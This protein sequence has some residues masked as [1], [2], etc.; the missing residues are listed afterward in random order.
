LLFWGNVRTA[1]YTELLQAARDAI[2]ESPSYL[3]P[4]R[5]IPVRAASFSFD[6][7]SEVGNLRNAQA[8]RETLVREAHENL[9]PYSHAIR[10]NVQVD[11][12]VVGD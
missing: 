12:R 9:C 1:P 3:L 2:P 5:E 7:Y 11:L 10:G 8:E 6:N 4:P